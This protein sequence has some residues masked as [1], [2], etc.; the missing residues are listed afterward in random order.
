MGGGKVQKL[1]SMGLVMRGPM[2]TIQAETKVLAL[3][4][5]KLFVWKVDNIVGPHASSVASF[6]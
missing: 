5:L 6:L 2:V 4:T 3:K 1:R